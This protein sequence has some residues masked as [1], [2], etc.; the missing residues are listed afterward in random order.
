M[1]GDVFNIGR[2]RLEICR[3]RRVSNGVA[4]A[5]MGAVTSSRSHGEVYFMRIEKP[6][7][8][9]GLTEEELP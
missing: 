5:V 2:F 3:V 4:H 1:F 6:K 8:P 9:F 7:P